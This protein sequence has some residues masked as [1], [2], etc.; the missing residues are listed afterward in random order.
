MLLTPLP[1]SGKKFS[2]FRENARAILLELGIFCVPL[3]GAANTK[4]TF[5]ILAQLLALKA[6]T[7]DLQL[8]PTFR[9]LPTQ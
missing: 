1:L 9:L 3:D 4:R 8:Q 2:D 7:D 5:S 6:T